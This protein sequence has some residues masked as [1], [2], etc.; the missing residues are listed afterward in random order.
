M[1]NEKQEAKKVDAVF[2]RELMPE[3]EYECEKHGK[4]TGTAIKIGF[5]G[6]VFDPEC[7]KCHEEN[8]ALL[9]LE[10]EK[11]EVED[12]Q[13]HR[14]NWL[15]R[16]NIGRRYWDTTFEN[17]EAY[18]DELKHHLE[19]CL[20]FAHNHNGRKLVMLGNNGTG[21]NHLAVSVMKL[22]GGVIHTVFEIEL[23]LRQ[24]YSGET[25]EYKVVNDLCNA[26]MLVI[27]EIGRTKG[28]DWELNWLSYVI[29]KRHENLMPIILISNKHLKEDCP[30]KGCPDCI[31]NFVGNDV[32]SRIIEDGLIMEFTGD[33]Y[34]YK[35]RAEK[36]A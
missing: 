13:R 16:M 8:E 36:N 10:K 12:K 1:V 11:K 18:T 33:D 2:G 25:Q 20:E 29:N 15:T 24:S 7:P 21:K 31:Q 5:L 14:I 3:K 26:E 4:F 28:G 34:R 23:M 30:Q 32:L 6:K 35:K 19:V 27:D 9:I 22:T 17:F